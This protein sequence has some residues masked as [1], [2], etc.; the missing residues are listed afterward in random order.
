MVGRTDVLS[1]EE[2]MDRGKW[3]NGQV[4]VHGQKQT[5]TVGE[6]K[7]RYLNGK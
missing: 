3:K 2:W 1:V 6:A 7:E 5:K 4:D